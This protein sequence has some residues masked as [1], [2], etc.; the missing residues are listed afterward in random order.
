MFKNREF[1]PNT[2]LVINRLAEA[3]FL[4]EV[5]TIAVL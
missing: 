5:Q 1:P 2:L 4:L 3:A